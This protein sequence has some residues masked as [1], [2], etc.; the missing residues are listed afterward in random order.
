MTTTLTTTN[1][2]AKP[3]GS[4]SEKKHQG[5][6]VR[7]YEWFLDWL[8]E[9]PVPIVLGV[10]WLGGVGLISV[11]VLVL[12]LLWLAVEGVLGG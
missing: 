9:L 4:K 11:G 5:R 10:L 3:P 6:L 7:L 2:Q 8:L 1:K 12:Y